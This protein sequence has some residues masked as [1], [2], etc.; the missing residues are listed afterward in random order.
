[1]AQK[2]T[3]RFIPLMLTVLI[4]ISDQLSKAWVVATIPENTIGFRYL[5][6]FLAIVHV[7]NT[8][9]A[10][11]MGDG[12]PVAVK[13]LFF[14]IVPVILVIAVCVVYFSR[15]I[16]L[17]VFQR[18]VLALFLGGGT[19]NLID[20]IF[21]GFRVV[22]FISVKVYGFLGF[23][24]WPTWNIAD[25]SLVVSGILLAASLLLESSETKEDNNV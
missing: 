25:A 2:D 4:I 17:S 11:S 1:M 22:D 20:R 8:A 6:D 15:K 12:L 9:I 10:F 24:R 5:G 3:S 16:H 23:E 19:G 18:W 13:L 7:R 14:I 21:R